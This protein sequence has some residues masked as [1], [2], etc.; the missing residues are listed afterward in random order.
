MPT[1]Q[2]AATATLLQL[3][4]SLVLEYPTNSIQHPGSL[5]FLVLR[6]HMLSVWVLHLESLETLWLCCC[7]GTLPLMTVQSVSHL[8]CE[9][10]KDSKDCRSTVFRKPQTP[11]KLNKNQALKEPWLKYWVSI[12]CTTVDTTTRNL[13]HHVSYHHPLFHRRFQC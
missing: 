8:C 11:K 3:P 9:V 7:S 12:Y 2:P 1:A 4:T 6:R 10:F 5:I 13:A